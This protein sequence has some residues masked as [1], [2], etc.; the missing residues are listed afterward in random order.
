MNSF[1]DGA[2]YALKKITEHLYGDKA[3]EYI[4]GYIQEERKYTGNE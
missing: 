1:C 2:F 4:E 3:I